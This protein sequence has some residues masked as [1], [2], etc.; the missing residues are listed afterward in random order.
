MEFIKHVFFLLLIPMITSGQTVH[1]DSGRIVYKGTIKLDSVNKDELYARAKNVFLSN[2]SGTRLVMITEDN[3]KE[4]ISAK[5]SMSLVSP[6][7][8]IK[9]VEFILELSIDD[10]SYKYRVDSVYIDEME[11][12]GKSN[13]ISSGELLK[14]MGVSGGVAA[15]S[16]KELNEIDMKFEK[17]IDLVNAAMKKSLVQKPSNEMRAKIVKKSKAKFISFAITCY[18]KG[19]EQLNSKISKCYVIAKG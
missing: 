1:I 11:R 2:I 8:I 12:G 18:A 4:M 19:Q 9:K 3:E 14:G 17:L 5:G 13:K 10:G 7:S 16:E 15:V 6:F